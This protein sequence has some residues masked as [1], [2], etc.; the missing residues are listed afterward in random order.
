MATSEQRGCNE[1]GNEKGEGE[2]VVRVG[3]G[4]VVMV[5]ARRR[6]HIRGGAGRERFPT[7]IDIFHRYWL[8]ERDIFSCVLNQMAS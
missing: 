4:G 5:V 3:G 7:A 2:A 6:R 8:G 1:V